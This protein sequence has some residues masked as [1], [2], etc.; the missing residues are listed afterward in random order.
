VGGADA[1]S[2]ITIC[3]IWPGI[4]FIKSF[5]VIHLIVVIVSGLISMVREQKIKLH[6]LPGLPIL[7]ASVLI[8]KVGIIFLG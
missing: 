6:R 8:L 3:L 5:L 4:F 7:L 1:I 2:A